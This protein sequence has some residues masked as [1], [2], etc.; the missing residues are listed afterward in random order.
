M[1]VGPFEFV[2]AFDGWD[3]EP[4]AVA[5]EIV[6]AMLMRGP[7]IHCAVLPDARRRWMRKGLLQRTLGRLVRRY[8]YAMTR[9]SADHSLGLEFVR[10]V[11]FEETARDGLTR[12]FRYV[13]RTFG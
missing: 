10:R 9:V 1:S 3:V 12:E 4:I 7:E 5:G 2:S 8:G 13:R 6:G 11:G